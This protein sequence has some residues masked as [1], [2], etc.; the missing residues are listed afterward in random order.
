MGE[1]AFRLKALFSP[2]VCTSV[3]SLFEVS[4]FLK[5]DVID[6]WFF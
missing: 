5:N 3:T 2:D 4:M 1:I 6:C